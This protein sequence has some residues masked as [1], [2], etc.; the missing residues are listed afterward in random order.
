[1]SVTKLCN[2]QIR[3]HA[4]LSTR[5]ASGEVVKRKALIFASET[6][7]RM[8]KQRRTPSTRY[9]N[10]ILTVAR[11]SSHLGRIADLFTVAA[12]PQDLA[13]PLVRSRRPP[14]SPWQNEAVRAHG[15][16][17]PLL[18]SVSAPAFNMLPE[19]PAPPPPTPVVPT[20]IVNDPY[21]SGRWS[22]ALGAIAIEIGCTV[23]LFLFSG[24]VQ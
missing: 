14:R 5:H 1:M 10:A 18:R 20:S 9:A 6:R 4:R 7:V 11:R 8:R 15:L 16:H 24:C 23:Q 19:A 13:A 22:A 12:R 21:R 2:N 17:A 3:A